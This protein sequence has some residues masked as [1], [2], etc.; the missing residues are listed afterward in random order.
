MT[1]GAV[2]ARAAILR[3][4]DHNAYETVTTLKRL[5]DWIARARE[6]GFVCINANTSSS[7]AMQA[8]LCGVSLAV[9]PNEACY[10]P[11]GHSR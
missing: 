2:A 10:V 7:D 9:A 8:E 3:A 5:D 11:C 1:V 4:I 6:T